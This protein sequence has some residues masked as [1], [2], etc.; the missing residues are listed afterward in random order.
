MINSTHLATKKYTLKTEHSHHKCPLNVPG[1]SNAV[2]SESE[3]IYQN[4]NLGVKMEK[5]GQ[6]KSQKDFAK[7]FTG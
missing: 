2:I 4:D 7:T 3:E 1:S 6:K 5:L